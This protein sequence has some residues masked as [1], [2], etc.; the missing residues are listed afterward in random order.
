M[1]R[2][3]MWLTAGAA[4]AV[5]TLLSAC[6]GTQQED[7]PEK[8]GHAAAEQSTAKSAK[9]ALAEGL[10]TALEERLSVHE[11]RYGSGTE[12]VCSTASPKMFSREC[13]EAAATTGED[14]AYALA[15]IEGKEGYATLR[16]VARKLQA[17][18]ADYERLACATNPTDPATRKACLDPAAAI[19]QGTTDLRDGTRLGLAGR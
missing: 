2:Q 17:A 6:S 13:A 8:P 3:Q 18:T 10:K 7:R 12:S 4:A 14:A 5:I 1:K 16:S 15:R 11:N 19:A 9:V